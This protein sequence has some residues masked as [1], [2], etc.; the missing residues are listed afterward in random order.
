MSNKVIINGVDVLEELE[1]TKKLLA[2]YK[3]LNGM[4]E[5]IYSV[6]HFGM[7]KLK[8]QIKELENND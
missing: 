6:E 3:K 2:L 4:Y 7:Y 1:K 5:T 8:Q